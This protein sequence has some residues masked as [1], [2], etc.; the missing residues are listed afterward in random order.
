[1]LTILATLSA[2]AYISIY[3]LEAP[4]RYVFYLVGKDWLILARDGFVFGP[5]AMILVAQALRFR[6]NP[7]FPLFFVLL[8]FHSLVMLG[9]TG[10]PVGAVYGIKVLTNLLFGFLLASLLVQPGRRMLWL[11][12][13]LWCV[14][15]LGVALDK[16]VV[17][18]PW[19]GIKTVIGD[20]N[21]DV[22]KDWEIQDSFA[23]RVAG[24][25]RSSIHV[26]GFVPL[27]AIVL[28]SASRSLL[29][30]SALLVGSAVAVFLTTQK[31]ALIAFIPTA[32]LL[33]IAWPGRLLL[34]R[35][36]CII[37][38]LLA[39]AVPF[40]T[41]GVFLPHGS[42]NFSLMSFAMRI[43]GTWPNA[44]LWIT[45]KGL[46]VFGVGLGGIG[47]GQILYAPDNLNPAD[48]IFL[49]MY[50]YFGV[51]T[52]LYLGF[53]AWLVLRPISGRQ[54]RVI[55]ALAILMFEFGY[56][57]VLSILEDQAATLFLGAA[58]G[59]LWLETRRRGYAAEPGHFITLAPRLR[60]L[61]KQALVRLTPRQSAPGAAP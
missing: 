50:A 16:F 58:T 42:G 6:V 46:G 44:I 3:A 48:N 33:W 59:V 56:G 13:G 18:F 47:G 30:R 36:G 4:I 41:S 8:M 26:A 45:R 32:A 34:L 51:F 19:N 2:A 28:M 9:T 10:S 14:T 22:S 35:L 31:G 60:R 11:L 40:L 1:M 15:L 25:T 5:L 39:C 55:P 43:N 53:V 17:T 23:R 7:A 57:I 27:L 52:F 54:D 37:F 49:L 29:I 12:A 21:V 24:F 20:V 38:M 61:T